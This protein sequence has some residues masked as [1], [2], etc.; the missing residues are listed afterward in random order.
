VILIYIFV[1]FAFGGFAH[2]VTS[3]I[4][5]LPP[6]FSN[7]LIGKL[8]V[9]I[10]MILWG[11]QKISITKTQLLNHIEYHYPYS[12]LTIRNAI[13]DCLDMGLVIEVHSKIDKRLKYIS[14]DKEATLKL[15]RNWVAMIEEYLPD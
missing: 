15:K 9:L 13:Q 8:Q 4:Q 6:E 5:T 1:G 11:N 10:L 3:N 7:S 14:I 12:S 2:I